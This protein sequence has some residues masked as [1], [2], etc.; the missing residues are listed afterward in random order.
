MKFL[1]HH[2]TTCWRTT[3][4]FD[5]LLSRGHVFRN[6]HRQE[7][8]LIDAPFESDIDEMTFLILLEIKP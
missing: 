1:L 6:V 8:T 3:F 4:L 2:S 7:V 5:L